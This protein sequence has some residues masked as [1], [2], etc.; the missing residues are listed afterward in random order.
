[1]LNWAAVKQTPVHLMK[2]YLQL[3]N[4]CTGLQYVIG[5]ICLRNIY[6]ITVSH[7]LTEA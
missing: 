5:W 7:T 6:A 3:L 4:D 1:M 2:I